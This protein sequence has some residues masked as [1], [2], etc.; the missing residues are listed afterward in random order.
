[1]QC[2]TLTTVN[3]DGIFPL[4]SE[5]YTVTVPMFSLFGLLVADGGANT[6]VTVLAGGFPPSP[7]KNVLRLLLS[8]PFYIFLGKEAKMGEAK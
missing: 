3:R 2:N 1:L 5:E 8:S 4:G 6:L 7:S